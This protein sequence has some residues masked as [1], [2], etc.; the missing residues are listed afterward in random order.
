MPDLKVNDLLKLYETVERDLLELKETLKRIP[1]DREYSKM[2]GESILQEIEKLKKY[3][4]EILT[5]PV[6][7][8]S[9]ESEIHKMEKIHHKQKTDISSPEIISTPIQ[10]PQ[11]IKNKTPRRY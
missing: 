9:N 2:I 10:M 1:Q 11:S 3:N 5:I 4:N 7:I 8:H 6:S